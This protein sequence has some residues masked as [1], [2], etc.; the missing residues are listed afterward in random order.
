[1][2]ATT[3]FR[4]RKPPHGSPIDEAHPYWR[5]A[6]LYVPLLEGVGDTPMEYARRS[7]VQQV[8]TS[9][10]S[11]VAG[12]AGG[13]AAHLAAATNWKVAGAGQYT[14]QDWTLSWWMR[15]DGTAQADLFLAGAYGGAPGWRVTANTDANG[16]P[17][18]GRLNLTFYNPGTNRSATGALLVAGSWQHWAIVAR[19][20]TYAFYRDGSPAYTWYPYAYPG[21]TTAALGINPNVNYAIPGPVALDN[22][23]SLGG[24]ALSAPQ[25][26]DLHARPWQMFAARPSMVAIPAI[27]PEMAAS[28]TVYA[29]GSDQVVSLTGFDLSWSGSP[30]AISGTPPAGVSIASQSVA[31]ATHA[32]VTLHTGSAAG[33]A[34]IADAGHSVSAPVP[35]VAPSFSIAPA[36]IPADHPG[37]LT[38]ALAGLGT[39]WS[40]GTTTAA[41]A[42]VVPTGCALVAGG[43]SVASPTSAT[44][45]VTTGSGAGPLTLL[46]GGE[47]ATTTVAAPALSASTAT[48]MVAT[49]TYALTLSDPN[50]A[51]TQETAATLFSAS[52]WPGA[53]IS[54]ISV[55][56]DHHATATLA[57]GAATRAGGT[58]AIL[59]GSTGTSASLAVSAYPAGSLHATA[60]AVLAASGDSG[61]LCGGRASLTIAFRFRVDSVPQTPH[62]PVVLLDWGS[63]Y[64][65]L[66]TYYPASGQVQFG[67]YSSTHDGNGYPHGFYP[68]NSA[69]A[70]QFGVEY[71]V[72][73]VWGPAAQ[74]ISI[75]GAPLYTATFSG[76]A[77]YAQSA[78]RFGPSAGS[79]GQ[80]DL[81]LSDVAIWSNYAATGAD[82]ADLASGAVTPLGLGA[83]AWW[84]LGGGAIGSAP[85]LADAGLADQTSNGHALSLASGSLPGLAYAAALG[86]TDPFL[87]SDVVSKSG[88]LA[89]FGFTSSYR[90]PGAGH[91]AAPVRGVAADP[92]IYRGGVAIAKG[93]ATW[94]S[95]TK[96]MPQ[97]AYL[98]ECGS[99]EQVAIA[100]GGAGYV[101]PS[102]TWNGD[103]GG[104]ALTLGTPVLQTGVVG[105]AITGGNYYGSSPS[106]SVAPPTRWNAAPAGPIRASARLAMSGMAVGSVSPTVGGLMGCGSGYS[107]GSPPAVTL[108]GGNGSG[109][110]FASTLTAGAFAPIVVTGSTTSGAATLTGLSST[111][112][113]LVGS[114]A[115]GAGIPANARVA[116]IGPGTVTLSANAT[117]TASGVSLSFGAI[118]VAKGGSGY[119]ASQSIPMTIADGTGSGASATAHIDSTGAVS[120]VSVEAAGSGY[121]SPTLAP[122][123]VAATA[124]AIVATYIAY[125]PVASSS[126][127]FTSA[128]TL[129]VADTGGTPTRVASL[130][131]MMSGVAPGDV[132]TCDVPASW[133]T[134][135]IGG[136]PL[137]GLAAATGLAVP[138]GAGAG[139][140]ASGGLGAFAQPPTMGA[141]A[142]LGAQL[143]DGS[144]CLA[145]TRNKSLAGSWIVGSGPGT[146]TLDGQDRPASW[147]SASATIL[148]KF[149]MGPIWGQS[150]STSSN[151]IDGSGIAGLA[152]RWRAQYADPL[153][154]RAGATWVEIVATAAQNAW[155]N[156]SGPNAGDTTGLVVAAADIALSGGALASVGVANSSL[157]SGWQG[158]FARVTGGGGGS[159]GVVTPLVSGGVITGWQVV[160]PGSGYTSAPTI[161]VYGAAVS[162]TTVQ[163]DVDVSYPSSPSTWELD[164]TLY[165][166]APGDGSDVAAW[167]ISDYAVLPPDPQS[168]LP[169]SYD[170]SDPLAPDAWL[171]AALTDGGKVASC[172]RFMDS[173]QDYAGATNF[174]LP[175]DLLDPAADNWQ[176]TPTRTIYFTQARYVNTDRS[177][178]TYGWSSTKVYGVQDG[179]SQSDAPA[180][181]SGTLAAGSAAVTGVSGPAL[182]AGSTVTG[183]G[184]PSGPNGEPNRVV[185]ISGAGST[186]TLAY[187]A[188]A[189]GA[190]TLAVQPPP[191][192]SPAATDHGAFMS[193][194]SNVIVFELVSPVP[195]GYMTGQQV[196]L[197]CPT[198]SPQLPFVGGGT[199]ALGTYNVCAWVT[200]PY[201]MASSFGMNSH[202]PSGPA[203]VASI[204]AIDLTAGGATAGWGSSVTNPLG[205]AT[206]PWEAAGRIL[207]ALPGCAGWFSL[208][209][210]GCR[211]LYEDIGRRV[212]AYAN[213]SNP[214]YLEYSN[215]V[216]NGGPQAQNF[217][218]GLGNLLGA[219]PAGTAALS[220]YVVNG[221]PPADSSSYPT[222]A[223]LIG[224]AAMSAFAA[225]WQ[226]AGR[227]ASAIRRVEGAW[228]ANSGLTGPY[229]LET[230]AA[231]GI[232]RDHVAV[233]P[234][235][236]LPGDAPILDALSPA[237][238][239]RAG[240]ASWPMGAILDLMR[241]WMASSTGTGGAPGVQQLWAQHAGIAARA[242]QPALNRGISTSGP[243]RV[244]AVLTPTTIASVSVASGG[245]GYSGSTTAS[246]YGGGGPVTAITPTLSGGS[247]TGF[248]GLPTGRSWTSPPSVSIR[249]PSGTGS[250]AQATAALSPTSVASLAVADP[251]VG[252]GQPG[253]SAVRLSIAAPPSGTAATGTATVSGTGI[254]AALATGGS[255]YTSPPAVAVLGGGVLPQGTYSLAFTYLDGSGNETTVGA[256]RSTFSVAIPSGQSYAADL[257][258]LTLPDLPSWAAGMNLYLTGGQPG[259]E[260]FYAGL[261]R[262]QWQSAGGRWPLNA[263]VPSQ[264][265]ARPPSSCRVPSATL[266]TIP[267][268]VTYEGG[269]D[270]PI[271][272]GVAFQHYLELDAFAHP[273]FADAAYAWYASC[274]QGA[275][276][277]AGGG[278][279][280]ANYFQLLSGIPYADLWSLTT[281]LGQA[282]GD[283]A[284]N[285]FATV[286][287]G[288]TAAAPPDGHDHNGGPSANVSPGLMGL[289]NWF[290]A[291]PPTPSRR[292]VPSPGRFGRPF[293]A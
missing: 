239:S 161:T 263:A 233:A 204:D 140:P 264:S 122:A 116:A 250:G 174:V 176:A 35:I 219:E 241:H 40:S 255:G 231:A 131:A 222:A 214:I 132:I 249:D 193:T 125:V 13:A 165:V 108:S 70:A 215:E 158:A 149:C 229:A 105:Y 46:V 96:D 95:S 75:N 177:S 162:G 216:W 290:G 273:A 63:G 130:S 275:Q 272:G 22:V 145:P 221:R 112:G 54:G 87:R 71:H 39:L 146:L 243:A 84:P 190:R 238:S 276:W 234:Y 286:Q 126:G 277:V 48:P 43:L 199:T 26:A 180:S 138:N 124:A 254:T 224:D 74:S 29:N 210:A 41:L 159:G 80:L 109:A 186:I 66:A 2:P 14:T 133:C 27:A 271:P 82:V 121:A 155:V 269:V 100:D 128:P 16:N 33:T 178:A 187:A 73:L 248:T 209:P 260:A 192:L 50:A 257:P 181:I 242:G 218:R 19:G 201:T 72:A 98:L 104:A 57:L 212:G 123:F 168:G 156:L 211:D 49:G 278:A 202:A 76:E 44:V 247:I 151:E 184:I 289:R 175:T 111:T 88:K 217:A 55:S 34:T 31:D 58:V 134:P 220:G 274:Q 129:T 157:G 154:N 292:W 79:A 68:S 261:T 101:S 153:V 196:Y 225:G 253:A 102:V 164:V 117:A 65:P 36:V 293:R 163:I 30:F 4:D 89:L 99:V 236:I 280:L 1:M 137:G 67:F 139:E 268:L 23:L 246:L 252:Y 93:P 37:E 281:S 90:P 235:L 227:P 119:P 24:L 42:G 244:S 170:P 9:A 182:L 25:V 81:R 191:Y 47:Q 59:D 183:A 144:R 206:I 228:W 8:G 21:A 166:A 83:S 78:P 148:K 103:G 10:P 194:F 62:D 185:G 92:T 208:P 94:T 32:T 213:D 86:A 64:G 179:F 262:S 188:T 69:L 77:T 259:S 118:G 18:A 198:G 141:G 3:I 207:A 61:A 173:C 232:A 60:A 205:S 51:W 53:S 282:A 6:D 135:T 120:Y 284:S 169:Q 38:L 223:T 20:G 56:D 107:A 285:R 266:G 270:V 110:T 45:R 114:A 291:A 237:G 28:G 203:V 283:G 256:S 85:T 195:H 172:L 91:Q 265:A 279:A 152:G 197:W 115:S 245:S 251:G 5:F 200:G 171:I 113:L 150:G 106:V 142:N 127:D 7:P 12:P 11:W 136:V 226:A 230:A 167:G 17:A 267:T 143:Q 160:C 287:G 97:V 147:T 189:S 258:T 52:G 288:G 240:A 15:I